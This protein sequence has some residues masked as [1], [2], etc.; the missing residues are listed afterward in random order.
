MATEKQS[1]AKK[2]TKHDLDAALAVEPAPKAKHVTS[3]KPATPPKKAEK[4]EKEQPKTLAEAQTKRE[5]AK[6]EKSAANVVV[7]PTAQDNPK[8]MREHHLISDEALRDEMK[9]FGIEGEVEKNEDGALVCSMY[10]GNQFI[11][12]PVAKESAMSS[13]LRSLHKEIRTAFDKKV[14]EEGKALASRIEELED[15]NEKLRKQVEK[16]KK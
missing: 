9:E 2:T 4:V 3:G 6:A 15:E 5:A 16:A 7:L 8:G 13:W 14:R 11:E 1:T 12:V 10:I